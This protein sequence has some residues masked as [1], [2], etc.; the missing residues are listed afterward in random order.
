M[1]PHKD[2]DFELYLPL[3][4]M[5]PFLGNV[6]CSLAF[7]LAPRLATRKLGVMVE[8]DI[9]TSCWV[10]FVTNEKGTPELVPDPKIRK[11]KIT[12]P[13]CHG[14]FVVVIVSS[15]IVH[16]VLSARALMCVDLPSGGAHGFRT[17]WRAHA[18]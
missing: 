9:A 12:R 14:V 8:V 2:N 3:Q 1:W 13:L 18:R 10:P 11:T 7:T 16:T 15:A 5:F 4:V 6:A 17:G